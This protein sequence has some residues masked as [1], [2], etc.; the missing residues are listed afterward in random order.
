MCKKQEI[1][2]ARYL[3]TLC[4]C[5]TLC[6]IFSSS[7]ANVYESIHGGSN[8]H[9]EANV[10]NTADERKDTQVGIFMYN[11]YATPLYILKGDPSC[12]NYAGN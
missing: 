1:F 7:F 9:E 8:I 2:A 3:V 11:L 6:V 10:R 4:Y 12:R 5:Q